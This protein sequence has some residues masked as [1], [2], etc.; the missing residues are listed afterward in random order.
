ME[1]NEVVLIRKAQDG[2]VAAFEKL[3]LRYDK[4]IMQLL[5]HLLNDAED[6]KDVYQD[7]FFKVYRSIGSFNFKSE[8][9][10]WLYRIAVNTAINFRNKRK[11]KWDFEAA[12]FEFTRSEFNALDVEDFSSNPERQILNSELSIKIAES[13]DRLSPKQR[14]VF[15][16]RH[17]QGMKLTEIAKIIQT[18][19]GTVKNYLFRAIQKMRASLQPYL[20]EN[21][22]RRQNEL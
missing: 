8:F 1:L 14:A 13:I 6:A 4:D 20:S 19:E 5:C 11:K 15:I 18:K 2:N 9:Y 17:Y 3:V 7:V 12:E 22:N 10:T 16:L 21:S